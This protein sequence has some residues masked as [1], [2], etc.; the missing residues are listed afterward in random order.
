MYFI[1]MRRL[2]YAKVICGKMV[3]GES[4]SDAAFTIY[5]RLTMKR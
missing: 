1:A 3:R 4:I 2:R 5:Y